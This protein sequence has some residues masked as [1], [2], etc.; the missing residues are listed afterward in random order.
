MTEADSTSSAITQTSWAQQETNRFFGD[1]KSPSQAQCN[2]IARAVFGAST[3]KLVDSPGSTSYTVICNRCSG[4]EQCHDLVVS[5]REQGAMLN[6]EMVRLAKEIH[7]GLVP[8]SSYHGTVDGADPSL[9]IYSM[10][11]LR[12][13][14][15]IQVSPYQVQMD[16]DE[17]ARHTT[18]MK[19]L[20]RYFARNWKNPQLVDVQTEAEQ[21][22]G[23]F[24]R[25]TKLVEV[26]GE[27]QIL[28][29]SKS[30]V[31]ELIET[32]PLLFSQDYPQVLTHGDFSVTNILVDETSFEITGIVDWALAAMLP[33][34]MDLD[35]LY[36]A[37]GFM[38]RDGWRDYAC[39]PRLMDAFWEEFWA[40]AGIEGDE[41]RGR[42]RGLA[43]AAGRIG[44]ILRLAFRRNA[45]GSASEE[46]IV[47]T[48][49]LGL[50][51]LMAWL[52]K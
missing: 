27:S 51:Q 9:L 3:V 42:I 4:S 22:Q 52:S 31:S 29:P 12:G 41:H 20:A 35:I 39:Q 38:T 14:A 5:F 19:N 1:R 25:L 47:S 17:E 13:E 40:G 15:Y 48:E 44:A 16:P 7:G 10:P 24:K 49:R 23:I 11:Y 8:E 6:D 30:M 33:F 34:G 21:Q 43:E 50:K 36:L 28:A 18:F 46:V 2:E 26:V 32:L 45:D 37:T